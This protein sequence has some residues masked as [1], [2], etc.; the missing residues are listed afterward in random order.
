[1]KRKRYIF[2]NWKMNKTSREAREF[3]SIFCSLVRDSS[4]TSVI[5]IAPPFTA[6]SACSE[7]I[8]VHNFPIWLGAQNLHQELS[9]AFTGEVALPM[10]QEFGVRFVLLGHSERRHIFHED[11]E[12]IAL[13]IERAARGGIIPIL[14]IGE[15]LEVK[16]GGRTQEMLSNQLVSGLSR[17]TETASIILAYEP[18]WAIGTGKAASITDVQEV[19]SF[20][21]QVLS[22]I[23]SK[24][25][26]E[27]VPILYGGSIKADNAR[28]FASCPDVDGLLV[29][30]ASMNPKEFSH[31][32][33]QF[34]V[35]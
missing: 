16:E 19:H 8:Q 3:L 17:L 26:A 28:S 32:I 29:G 4:S 2:G 34:H 33:E 20:C 31:V 22:Q 1:M 5:G 11:D 6:L 23:F 27:T 10:L 13:K 25:K 12:T 18:V 9:G 7:S 14:C 35:V 15:T 30:G 24:E 21:R